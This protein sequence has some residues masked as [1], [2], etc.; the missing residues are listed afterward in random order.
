[1]VEDDATPAGLHATRSF[2]PDTAPL[3]GNVQVTVNA[4]G[5]GG[6]GEVVE[7]LVG[8]TYVNNSSTLPD[9]EVTNAGRRLSFILTGET[10]FNYRVSVPSVDEGHSIA[11]IIKN[12][13]AVPPEEAIV[14]GSSSIVIGAAPPRP[15]TPSRPSRARAPTNRA[16]S[17]EEGA[18]ATRSVAENSA[19]GTAV[20]DPIT[21]TDRDDDDIAYSLVSGD[22]ELFDINKSRPA[23]S[24]WPRAQAS[25]SSPRAPT[26]SPRGSKTT[27]GNLTT[28]TS[29]SWSPMW[30][31][32]G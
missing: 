4:T 3:G 22:T 14:G 15:T 27:V 29:A 10:S 25:T 12:I 32:K 26:P 28:S 6:V 13:L 17:F 7:T 18:S 23:N 30:T 1:M 11:G 5:Y 2:S 16:P 20:G 19:A 31:K 21:A 8:Y 9:V 24:L